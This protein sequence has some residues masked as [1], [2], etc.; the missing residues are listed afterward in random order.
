M[1]V[2]FTGPE[3]DVLLEA[4]APLQ[5]DRPDDMTYRQLDTLV[6]KV[7]RLSPPKQAPK[8]EPS[9]LERAVTAQQEARKHW[10][11]A[12]HA[13]H[14]RVVRDK[15]RKQQNAAVSYKAARRLYARAVGH[16]EEP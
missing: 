8:V 1:S 4:L 5:F 9:P 13:H 3:R 15:Q 2:R 6:A 11:E 7:L 16:Q 14:N 12:I 10:V